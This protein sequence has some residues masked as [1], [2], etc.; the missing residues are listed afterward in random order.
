[1]VEGQCHPLGFPRVLS[2]QEPH[3]KPKFILC[4]TCFL[5][6]AW[7]IMPWVSNRASQ[8][9]IKFMYSYIWTISVLLWFWHRYHLRHLLEIWSGEVGS[10]WLWCRRTR[11]DCRSIIPYIHFFYI[12]LIRSCST[13]LEKA[14]V[15]GLPGEGLSS[16][17]VRQA[18]GSLCS[19]ESQKP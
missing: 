3:Q 9:R 13:E 19:G 12:A 5:K 10:L 4:T 7:V 2:L 16:T 17:R 18:W 15:L 8:S 11:Q 1:V 14:V 6:Q